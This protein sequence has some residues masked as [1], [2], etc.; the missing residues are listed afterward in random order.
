MMAKEKNI[1][2][3]LIVSEKVARTFQLAGLDQIVNMRI[4]HAKKE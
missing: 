4:V 1:V 2:P 3:N